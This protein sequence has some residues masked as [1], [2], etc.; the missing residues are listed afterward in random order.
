MNSRDI[1]DAD[2]DGMAAPIFSMRVKPA[3]AGAHEEAL[4]S[5]IARALTG[6]MTASRGGL[7]GFIDAGSRLGAILAER[8]GDLM[9][10]LRVS[11]VLDDVYALLGIASTS[12][13]VELDERVDD[14]ELKMDHVARI[15]T[16]EELMLLHQRLG[17]LEQAVR[18]RG[19][20]YDP[21]IDLSGVIGRLNEIESRIDDIPWSEGTS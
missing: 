5:D 6:L 12:A 1:R 7:G 10:Q 3:A 4:G 9:E 20:D 16:R 18:T 8:G 19:A 21:V 2:G 15:R 13:L 14:V 11:T 17:E